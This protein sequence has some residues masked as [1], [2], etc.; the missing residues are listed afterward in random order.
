MSRKSIA[1]S[2]V[3]V[4]ENSRPLAPLSLSIHG[5]HIEAT[6]LSELK[7]IRNAV[8]QLPEPHSN[9]SR[10]SRRAVLLWA[11]AT[12]YHTAANGF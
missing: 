8:E 5:I 7:K 9:M 4:K 12:K 2:P 3:E 6:H 1:K 11:G 10:P